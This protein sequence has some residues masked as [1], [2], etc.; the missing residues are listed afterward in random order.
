MEQRVKQFRELLAEQQVSAFS[1]WE[2]E[3]HKIVFDSRYLLLASKERKQVF[4]K[5][6]K[7]RADE[8]KKERAV[9]LKRKRD[10]Y[11]ELLKEAQVN[12]KSN[13]VDFA[14]K[15]SRDE[16]FKG[17]E[18]MKEK[19]SLFNDYQTEL[20]KKEKDDKYVEKE[21]QRKSLYSC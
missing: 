17:I 2:K 16:R 14:S 15:H 10:D 12:A 6:I 5:Y 3:L 8:E 19:E 13:F 11:R 18:K 21:K 1:T 4:E 9:A 7:E 20:R